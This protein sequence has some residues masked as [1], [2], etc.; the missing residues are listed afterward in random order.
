MSQA[1]IESLLIR[2]D[3][4]HQI[5]TFIIWVAVAIAGGFVFGATISMYWE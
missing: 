4:R 1:Q 3:R 2:L 5:L